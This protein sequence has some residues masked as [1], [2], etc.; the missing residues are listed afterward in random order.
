MDLLLTHP[1]L[2]SALFTHME[3]SGRLHWLCA[4]LT[5]I[6][7]FTLPQGQLNG[8]LILKWLI[9]DRSPFA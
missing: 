3:S 6:S 1:I 7:N 4:A 8:L 2:I 5:T 9:E